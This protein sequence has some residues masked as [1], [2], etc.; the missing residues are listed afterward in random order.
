MIFG[1]LS[2]CKTYYGT[3][4]RFEMAFNF[5]KKAIKENLEVGKYEIEGADLYASV[6]E[7]ST[8][9]A[10]EGKFEAHK[11]YIDIQFIISGTELM[12]VDHI[13]KFTPKGEYNDVKDVIFYLD[14]EDCVQGVVNS[15][16][17]GIFFPEDVHK[18]GMSYKNNVCSVKKIVVKV[19]V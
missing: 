18:P 1:S 7:Y 3:H 6:Q 17:Y 5:I 12:E 15:G 16:E 14:K 4:P 9:V 11:N 13:S 8:K 10:P 19:R 2:E